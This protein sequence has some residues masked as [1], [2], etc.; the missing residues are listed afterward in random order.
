MAALGT[1]PAAHAFSFTLA[2]TVVL[3][4]NT[5]HKSLVAHERRLTSNSEFFKAAMNN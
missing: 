3:L 4:V 1:E 5:D 2:G